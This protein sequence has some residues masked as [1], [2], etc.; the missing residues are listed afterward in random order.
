[1]DAATAG[2][3]VAYAGSST[4]RAEAMREATVGLNQRGI[5]AKTWESL[6]IEGR[7]LITQICT[8]I[9]SRHALLADVSTVNENVLFE[10]GFSLARNKIILLAFDETD[11]S[12]QK[13]WSDLS[14][15]TTIGRINYTGNGQKLAAHVSEKQ[16]NIAEPELL[17]GLLAGARA[18]ESN[19]VFAPSLPFRTTAANGL[20][21]FLERQ[22]HLVIL[23]AGDDLGL[24]P[25]QFY[26]QEIY[27]SSAAI[28]HLLG[29]QRI[30]ATEHNSRA[31]LLAG[32]AYGLDLPILI[33][34]EAGYSP[35]LDFKDMLYVYENS[36]NLQNHVDTWLQNLPHDA[37]A[38]NKRLGRLDLKVELPIRSF[39]QYV[40]E[41]ERKELTDYFIE[42]NEF[43]EIM[44]DTSKI[45]TGRKGTGK[46]ATMTQA[47]AELRK[48]RRNLV[49]PIKPSS[50]ELSGL[51]EILHRVD[52]DSSVE[53][54]LI[55]LWTYLIYSE[56]AIRTLS[57]AADKPAGFG[58]SASLAA[59][60]K[61]I[62]SLMIDPDS[63][64]SSRL[65]DVVQYM[66]DKTQTEDVLSK[67]SIS[68]F[69]RV[70]HI[71]KLG[72][73]IRA[74]LG[75]YARVAVILDNL[76]KTWERG[77]DYLLMSKFLLSLL[78]TSGRI[79]RQFAK[80]AKNSPAV[81]V[82]ISIFLRTD[83]Y[84]V[85]AKSAREP[86]KIGA[87]SIRW[88]DPELLIR[89]LEERYAAKRTST[90]KQDPSAMWH[91][92]FC[93]G[94][95]HAYPRLHPLEGSP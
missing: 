70:A 56:V 76:D 48:D 39:G 16:L 2:V 88:N 73:S 30:R 11:V 33:L 74:A 60:Q 50:Y 4:L 94:E 61:Q 81:S 27:R 26:V 15:L 6:S 35:P 41:Y 1:M 9:D 54:L 7:V 34:A 47:V 8:E 89:V 5:D 65:E 43:R 25:L 52:S 69:L 86:D 72:A 31:S 59:L 45:F 42:T 10:I 66:S 68:H 38:P 19:A 46:T 29:P 53:Y 71:G 91:E 87:L 40:A 20:E 84:E 44:S 64:M 77:A 37:A 63:D 82:T 92:F 83:I 55:N 14:L 80:S 75:D 22:S 57:L 32:F 95:G 21:G 49:V 24:A 79:E 28:F 62:T 13:S 18:R 3:F 36:A 17:E 12:A 78:T 51:L 93:R 90:A 23:G 85:M 58:G 67:D